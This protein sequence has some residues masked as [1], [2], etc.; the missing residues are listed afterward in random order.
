MLCVC[1]RLTHNSHVP[2]VVDAETAAARA[3]WRECCGEQLTQGLPTA[4]GVRRVADALAA[5][6]PPRAHRLISPLEHALLGVPVSTRAA[7]GLDDAGYG[8]SLRT[9]LPH[10]LDAS[11]E[12]LVP[13]E[14]FARLLCCVGPFV[15]L[16]T[17]QTSDSDDNI[18]IDED[19]TSAVPS[20]GDAC[21]QLVHA[22]AQRWP[23]TADV[24]AALDTL[25]FARRLVDRCARRVCAC[26]G[27]QRVRV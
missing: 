17:W 15:P 20:T 10:A 11:A 23:L 13:V 7:G 3:F 9:S 22:M 19:A 18:D 16:R 12:R 6:L 27:L 26:A 21:A 5:R 25:V 8:G 24:S 1:A 4:C 2:E 14:R